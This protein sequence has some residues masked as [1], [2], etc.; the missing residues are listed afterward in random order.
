MRKILALLVSLMLLAFAQLT[1]AS[2]LDLPKDA[3]PSVGGWTSGNIEWV[4]NVLI[5]QD[6]VGGR[7][8]GDYFYANDQ[9][10]IMIFD[11]KDPLNPVMTDFY[12]LPQEW[13]LSREDLD[14]NGE[15]LVMPNLSDLYVFDVEDKTN[16][17][18][19]AQVPGGQHTQSCILDC[20]YAYGSD[21]NIHD[22]RN[23]AKPKLLDAKWGDKLPA[24]GGHD[25]EEVAPGK[26]LTA[27]QPVMLLDVRK[28]PAKPKL[29]ATGSNIDGRFIHSGRWA[30]NGKDDF[31]LMG[32][33][34][35]LTPTCAEDPSRGAVMT[36]DATKWKKTGQFEM[37]D[38]Y[39]AKNGTYTDGN[40]PA[41][42]GI[43]GCSSHWLE[44][45]P[46]FKNGGVVAAAFF[47]H[48]VRLFDITSKGQINEHGYFIPYGSEAGAVY[49]VTPEIMYVLDYNRGI[50][51]LRYTGKG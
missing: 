6:G 18:L 32:G 25:I 34:K 42:P 40:P 39:Y 16:I 19:L 17:Q 27:T 21:G 30:Q 41:N 43:G 13:E 35:N 8:V 48:G 38:E 15:I 24:R 23:P 51:I 28:D 5:S 29:L 2:T 50:D 46:K 11:V 20:T 36:W 44:A 37:I 10:K 12:P 9:N 3:E 49:W 4:G 47:G 22:L 1:Q 33:E 26:V 7:L 31:L 14:T 45:H